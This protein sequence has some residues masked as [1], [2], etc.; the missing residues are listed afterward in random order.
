MSRPPE[1]PH[2]LR[3]VAK[4]L[5]HEPSGSVRE[6][7]PVGHDSKH[8]VDSDDG[9][10]EPVSAKPAS[11]RGY[12][13]G[14]SAERGRGR[15]DDRRLL[16]GVQRDPAIGEDRGRHRDALT[17]SATSTPLGTTPTPAASTDIGAITRGGKRR[18]PD[19]HRWPREGASRRTQLP[20][21]G[22]LPQSEIPG[23][24]CTSPPRGDPHPPNAW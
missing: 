18:Q 3:R 9:Q 11:T 21:D 17:R 22:V 8:H 20:T 10:R 19:C 13:F 16:P 15:R 7:R 4:H 1:E 6:D 2:H 5:G 14:L 23:P 12:G 24:V